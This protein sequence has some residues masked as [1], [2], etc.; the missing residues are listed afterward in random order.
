MNFSYG[1]PGDSVT[2]S[3]FDQGSQCANYQ[4]IPL[5]NT[6]YDQ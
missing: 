2:I 1:V 3:V 6:I 4:S 5:V